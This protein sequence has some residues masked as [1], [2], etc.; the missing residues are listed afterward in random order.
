MYS[1]GLFVFRQDLRLSDNTALLNACEQCNK[2]LPVFIFDEPILSQFQRPDA[3][4]G[5]LIETL[6][7]LKEELKTMGSDLLIFHGVSTELIPQ[8]A[9]EYAIDAVFWN[10]SYG[11]G[12][13]VRDAFLSEVL[14]KQ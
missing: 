8:L 3:R 1:R 13:R 5:F 6:F 9:Q 14:G 7:S 4:V 10:K 11:Q 12:S 2:L